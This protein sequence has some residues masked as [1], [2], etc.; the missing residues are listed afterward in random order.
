[1]FFFYL[2]IKSFIII[3]L[4]LISVAFFTLAERKVI[5]SVQRRLGPNAVGLFGVLQPIADG[6]KAILKENIL[7]Q[8][9]Q[10]FFFF[11]SPM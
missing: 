6:L 1:M 5:A 4:L 7:P 10:S 11:L 9:S 3:L 8:R 2:V